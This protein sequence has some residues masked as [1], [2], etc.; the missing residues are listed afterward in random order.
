MTKVQWSSFKHLKRITTT[1]N[2]P[3]MPLRGLFNHGP[4][5]SA[6][7]G[8]GFRIAQNAMEEIR[9][10]EQRDFHRFG[11]SAA[12][13]AVAESFQQRAVVDHAPGDSERAKPVLFLKQVYA[14][15]YAD[16]GIR[17]SQRRRRDANQSQAAMRDCCRKADRIQHRTATDD[18]DVTATIH[19]R[20]VKDLEHPFQNMYVILHGLATGHD[21]RIADDQKSL[22]VSASERMKSL[23]KIRVGIRDMFVKPELDAGGAGF[24]RFEQIRKDVRIGTKHIAGKSQAMRE[25]DFEIDIHGTA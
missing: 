15:L 1:R 25:R 2:V 16:P 12:E 5:C 20:F 10:L 17:L 8:T 6:S 22:I 24:G 7:R 3:Q 21:L 23:A 9:I 18:D 19:V 14:I 13:V 4:A 11:K